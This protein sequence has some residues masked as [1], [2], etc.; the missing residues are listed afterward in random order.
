MP[1]FEYRCSDCDHNFE[2]L[3]FSAS[4]TV[5]CPVC[6]ADEVVRKPSLFGTAGLEKQTSSSSP[7]AGC[8]ATSCSS[9]GH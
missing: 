4:S 6:G 3:L 5:V 9:C 8:S 7:C 1:I 2:K